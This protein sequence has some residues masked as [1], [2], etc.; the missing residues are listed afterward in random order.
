MT[1]QLKWQVKPGLHVIVTIPEHVCNHA[2]KRGL[3]FSTY[4][5]QKFLMKD[6]Y[7]AVSHYNYRYGYQAKFSNH[8]RKHLLGILKTKRKPGLQSHELS[9][10]ENSLL[11]HVSVRNLKKKFAENTEFPQG[12][13]KY[14][15][16]IS[17]NDTGCSFSEALLRSVC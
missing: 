17:P 1:Y 9:V 8:V 6:Q 3:N 11:F 10:S 7:H 12:F 4:R 14:K 16:Q 5:L 15:P 13:A 2:V